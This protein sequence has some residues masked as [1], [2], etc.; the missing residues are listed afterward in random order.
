MVCQSQLCEFGSNKASLWEGESSG[1]QKMSPSGNNQRTKEFFLPTL[2]GACRT[3]QHT[4]YLRQFINHVILCKYIPLSRL[5]N[6]GVLFY[7]KG[8]KIVSALLLDAVSEIK[9]IKSRSKKHLCNPQNQCF[10]K[11][12]LKILEPEI[13][14]G[15][16]NSF[17]EL[18]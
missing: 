7:L 1:T 9:S 11:I 18:K 5:N 15:I 3:P 13:S 2:L 17:S 8:Q 4:A 16:L 14:V 12:T 10:C 6:L